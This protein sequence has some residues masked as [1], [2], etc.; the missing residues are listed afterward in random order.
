VSDHQYAIAIPRD[1][2]QLVAL[3]VRGCQRFLDQD[4]LSCLERSPRKLKVRRR[5]GGY[6]DAV[7]SIIPQNRRK[8]T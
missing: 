2:I 7:Y 3:G 5:R 6:D 4:V 8:I 1:R